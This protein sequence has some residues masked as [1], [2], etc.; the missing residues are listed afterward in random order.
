MI[1]KIH[2]KRIILVLVLSVSLF[3]CKNY[4][5]LE[6]PS[7]F[8]E[9]YVFSNLPNARSAVLGVYDRL[10][11]LQAYGSRLSLMYPYDSDEMVGVLNG[12][13]PDN[14]SRDLSRYNL[15]ATNA[16]LAGPFEQLYAG[17]E[18]A[19]ICIK[20]IPAMDQYSNGTASEQLELKR[21]HG[22]ALTLRAQ[23]YFE[24]IRNWGDL[25]APFEP[26]AD[27]AELTLPKV[28]RDTIYN[29]LIADLK[30]AQEL[31][32]WRTEA[33]NDE[34][35]T[36]GAAKALRARLALYRAGFSL[37]R[38][39]RMERTGDY[40][41]FYQIARDECYELM[42]HREQHTLNP[43]FQ[44]VFKDGI[45]AYTLDPHGEILFE[46]AM[47]RETDSNLGYYD[48]P[49]FYVPGNTSLLGNGQIRIIPAY[50]YA[51]DSLDTRRDVTCAPYYNDPDYS[52]K[53]QPLL[54]MTSG[55]FR[56][57]W[58]NPRLSSA[59]QATGL[60]WPLIRFSD[61]LLMFA[62]AENELHNGPT[63]E[64]ILAL[65]EVRTRAYGGNETGNIPN[66]KEGFFN[67]LVQER[68]L[69][70]GG[71]GIRKYDLIRWN[72][73][74]QKIQEVRDVLTKMKNKV[75]P[76][77]QL[78]QYMYYKPAEQEVVWGNSLYKA[79]PAIAPE[80]FVRVNWMAALTDVWITNVA[81]LFR[82]NHS[83][84]FPIPQTAID[85][86]PNLTQDY[87]Y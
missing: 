39:N 69:E 80:G 54:N 7:A 15:Q 47:G 36:K 67:S 55:K 28:D 41:S 23:F 25:P 49:R 33:S 14:S 87:G 64:A 61:V 84:L 22:E 51:F 31:L 43:S 56:S 60:N 37:R 32:P 38:S 66:D 86:N 77:D 83:E 71:E 34:R 46:V 18:R 24:L 48:G 9:N 52:K 63:S 70:F 81:Q 29:R 82:A 50:F 21:L 73:I 72:L 13:A 85:A 79:S 57:D 26:A 27:Q 78:P 17:V 62:E 1:S 45:D 3:S 5:D 30:T 8:S 2:L 10:S 16:Q 68:Y 6:P 35:I 59:I 20:N 42:Q 11:G 65:Q 19:N 12:A 53:V 75:A 76:Y 44:A 40:L 4:L 74:G 58:I